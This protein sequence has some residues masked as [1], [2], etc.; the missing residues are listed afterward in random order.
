MCRALLLLQVDRPSVARRVVKFLRD[1]ALSD[2]DRQILGGMAPGHPDD[3]PMVRIVA[4]RVLIR[5]FLGR[6]LVICADQLEDIYNLD[7]SRDR[8]AAAMDV[9]KTIA[10]EPG[11][12]VVVSCLEEFYAHLKA[13]LSRSVLERL[14]RILH[15]RCCGG[16]ARSPR[17]PG[18]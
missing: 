15:R 18:W 1:E 5:T 16:N 13:E 3:A 6:A 10:E 2:H 14:D 9:L 8:F 7:A 12:V 11:T 4:L 17:S